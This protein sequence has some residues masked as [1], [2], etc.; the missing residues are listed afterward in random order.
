MSLK[1]D[2]HSHST[3]SDGTL[4]PAQLVHLAAD[5]GVNVLALTDHD[6]VSGIGQ[7]RMAA[8]ERDISIVPGVEISVSWNGHTVHVLGLNIDPDAPILCAGLERLCDYRQWRAREIGRRLAKKGIEGAYEGACEE[9]TGALVGRLHFARFLVQRGHARDV[10]EVFRKFLV[11]GNPGYVSGEWAS[12][13][14][15][16]GW[17]GDAG[18]MAVIA[19]PA[20]Y[21]MTRGKLRRLIGEFRELGGRGLEVVSGSHSKD[22]YFTMARHASDFGLLASAG[23]DFHGPENPWINLGQ[24]PDLPPGCEPVWNHF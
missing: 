17:I 14:E 3:V 23:S 2:L 9:A 20:R 16:L 12:L 24:L 7:A 19:H 22:E 6:N 10:K 1:Y 11:S 8:R 13:E 5:A 4:T 21:N 18:G 15:A